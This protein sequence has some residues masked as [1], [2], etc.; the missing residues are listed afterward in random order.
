MK[1][2]LAFLSFFAVLL[3]A[4]FLRFPA[5]T[6]RAAHTHN[7][8]EGTVLVE[9]ACLFD[10]RIRYVCKD[11][12]ETEEELLPAIGHHLTASKKNTVV[13]ACGYSETKIK[14]FGGSRQTFSCE[15]GTLTLKISAAVNGE[16]LFDFCE[17][18]PALAEEYR[19]FYPGFA[20]AYLFRLE[21]AGKPCDMTEEMSLSIPLEKEFEGY[22]LKVAL[23][24]SG[25][26]YYLE[27][28]EIKDGA[29][30]I[31]GA[32]LVGAEAV[33]FEKGEQVTMSIAV[34][35][36]V[37]VVTLILAAGM[38]VL[39]LFQNGKFRKKLIT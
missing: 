31:D 12:G 3:T 16:Y 38:I 34:P 32:E 15:K 23:L 22:R 29:V 30:L 39:I 6:V 25:R 11:C 10:G 28:F 36:T 27:N 35:I 37:T 24:R 13:C 7:F 8:G 5:Q 1:R 4:F 33:F 14:K 19:R 17:A 26:F 21:F 20:R 18:A 9:A 2:L